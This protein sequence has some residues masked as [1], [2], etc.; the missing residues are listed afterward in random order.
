M[1]SSAYASGIPGVMSSFNI[2]D[3]TIPVLGITSYL[4]GLALGP[5]IL[6]PLSE[7]YGR[8][9]IYIITM[10][11]F[12]ILVIPCAT[13]PNLEVLLAMRFLGAFAGSVMVSNAPGT[14]KDI[15]SDNYAALAFSIWC[16]GTINGVSGRALPK[17][18]L[19]T[20]NYR[21][22]TTLIFVLSL[23][24]DPS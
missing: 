18:A 3:R 21:K 13:A 6:A 9:P 22:V 23:L 15:A 17:I 24:L 5:L 7:M 16:I 19:D 8:R 2:L 12:A 1:Y 10:A 14:V 11:L 20:R 4:M